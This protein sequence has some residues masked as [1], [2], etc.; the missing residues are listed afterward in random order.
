MK[1]FTFCGNCKHLGELDFD[2][3]VVDQT[4]NDILP[5]QI[6][7]YKDKI[8]WNETNSWDRQIRIAKNVLK[9]LEVAK[10]LGDETIAII[11]SDIIIPRLRNIV[12]SETT[13][14]LCYPLLYLWANEI[15]PF[16]SG[17][18][19]IIP[20]RKIFAVEHELQYFVE[21]RDKIEEK[22]DIF[23]HDH[24]MHVNA[25]IPPVSHYI[26]GEKVTY[27]EN[28]IIQIRKHIPELTL[29]F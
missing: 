19:Y 18:N 7:K 10:G 2:Y 11:D 29:V 24:I 6:E 20:K 23:V 1:I 28:D 3:V 4:Y 17:T 21:H 8:I 12:I 15:R 22:V 9:A 13:L 14:T 25:F 5:E 26:Y 16:C 27:T